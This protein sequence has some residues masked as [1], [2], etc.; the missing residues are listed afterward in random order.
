MS[1]LHHPWVCLLLAL[2]GHS[3][4]HSRLPHHKESHQRL[5][6]EAAAE[7]H[8]HALFWRGPASAQSLECKRQDAAQVRPWSH[9]I[10]EGHDKLS[11]ISRRAPVLKAAE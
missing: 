3:A 8:H 9:H 4:L 2:S 5:M 1:P 7:M 11:N 10:W 6:P